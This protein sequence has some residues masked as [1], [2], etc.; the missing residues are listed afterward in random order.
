[1]TQSSENTAKPQR[2]TMSPWRWAALGA[3]LLAA[4]PAAGILAL[5][6]RFD[7]NRYAPEIIA[8]VDQATGRQLHLSGPLTMQ[9]SLHPVIEASGISLSNPPGFAG[10]QMLTL[11]RVEARI[12]LLPLLAHRLNILK[13]VLVSPDIVLERGP[14][15]LSNWDFTTAQPAAAMTR[16]EFHGYQAALQAV[17]IENGR[18][19]IKTPTPTIIALP[20]LTGTAASPTAPLHIKATAILGAAPFS[21]SGVVGPIARF[22]GIGSEPWPVDLTVKL[23]SATAKVQGALARPR[24]ASGYSLAVA[25]NIPALEDLAASLPPGLT[26]PLPPVHDI[27]A[28]ARITGQNS[29]IPAIDDL[30]VKAGTSD[31][32]SLRPGL[33]LKTLD[34]AMASLNQPLSLSAAATL[35]ST[36]LT[37]AGHFGP[38][39]ALLNPALLPARTGPPGSFPVTINA[40]FGPATASL[41]GAIATPATL[42]GAALALNLTIPDLSALSSAMGA[43]LPAWKN[44]T[45]QTTLIDPGGLGL[46][47]AIGLDTLTVNMDNAAF[48]GDASLYFG[49]QPRL[50]L[51]LQFTGLNTD[52]LL[53]AMPQPATAPANPAPAAAPVFADAPLALAWLKSARADVQISVDTLI[54]R[55]MTYTALQGHAVLANGQL[56]VSP[57]TAQL[58]GG[59]LTARVSVDASKAPAVESLAMSA[60]ALALAPMLKAFGLPGTAEGTMQ[61]RLSATSSGDTPHAIAS[62]LNEQLGLAMANGVVDGSVLQSLFGGVL[63]TAGLPAG[64][65][66][67]TGPVPVRCMALRVDAVGGIA[68][69]RAMALDSSRLRLQGSG[70]VN[71]GGETLGVVLL[72][73]LPMLPNGTGSPVAINGSFAAPVVEAAPA[74]SI[75]ATSGDICPAAL[76]LGRFGQPGPAAAITQPP[77]ASTP[78]AVSPPSGGPKNLLNGLLGP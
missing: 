75:Q 33:T 18:L 59:N 42:A 70:S 56:T 13:L 76:K 58:P 65:A 3:L 74:G 50:Q 72:P 55:Q 5:V 16:H 64:L 53:A 36:P 40:Q 8:A 19:T 54:W 17:E 78:G 24:T 66:G 22:S 38:P 4:L 11:K 26:G 15:G 14:G 60:P 21:V 7:P 35:G 71:A 48:G 62:G 25:L 41:T 1:M 51:A 23:G 46:R 2:R 73:Q 43:S 57:L 31:L 12:A 27:T 39:W 61:V 77:S 52:A 32:S 6:E 69:I 30:S 68:T 10:A 37:L 28:S 63:Q 34:I 29:T 67:A 47:N 44:I 9:L 45:A 49:P 20:N